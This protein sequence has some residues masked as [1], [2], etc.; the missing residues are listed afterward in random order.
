MGA[1]RVLDLQCP[2]TAHGTPAP[3]T[4]A[5]SP[6]PPSA[7]RVSSPA[8]PRPKVLCSSHQMAV[9]LPAGAISGIYVKGLCVNVLGVYVQRHIWLPS[10]LHELKFNTVVRGP[11][12]PPGEWGWG[13]Y[14]P[15]F[16]L[17]LGNISALPGRAQKSHCVAASIKRAEV[18]VRTFTD[19]KGNHVKLRDAPK[20][21]GYSARRNKHG[22]IQLRLQLHLR[23]HM[24]VQARIRRFGSWVFE[25]WVPC[26][27]FETSQRVR[28]TASL[29]AT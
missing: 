22:K 26:L 8:V 17:W 5:A 7:T 15:W 16:L 28:S 25:N 1:Y 19:I 10:S 13:K 11:R 29:S 2:Q 9:E 23:C 3:V 4:V 14:R 24:S 21:C 6:R 18:S 20:D 27:T 12:R